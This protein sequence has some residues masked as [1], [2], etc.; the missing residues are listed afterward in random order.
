MGPQAHITAVE[1]SK[2]LTLG[3][4]V[5]NIIAHY[6]IV[7]LAFFP[8]LALAAGLQEKRFVC[9]LRI[10][11]RLRFLILRNVRLLHSAFTRR[12]RCKVEIGKVIAWEPWEP[13]QHSAFISGLA[14]LSHSQSLGAS[15]WM[16]WR[17]NVCCDFLL[18]F[19][20]SMQHNTLWFQN[21]K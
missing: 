14:H 4:M 11:R 10:P 13:R 16:Y 1:S 21:S 2:T 17:E 5:R 7:W 18:R 15:D 9:A 19:H 20:R 8:P 3:I 6:C 12:K